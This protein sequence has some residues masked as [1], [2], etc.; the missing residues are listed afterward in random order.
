[1]SKLLSLLAAGTLALATGG[2]VIAADE[3]YNAGQTRQSETTPG[4]ADQKAAEYL[5]ALK[6][7]EVI[8]IAGGRRISLNDLLKEI[9]RVLG[10]ALDV[11]YLDPRPG[12]VRHSLADIARA[13]ELLGYEP[14]VRW[15][16]GIPRT[17]EFLREL[18][19]RGLT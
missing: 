11:R 19:E 8:N 1:M 14:L 16:D 15:E 12:D 18:I 2:F 17:V 9:G 6:K 5:A 13:K 4:N 10:R 7:C 3:P